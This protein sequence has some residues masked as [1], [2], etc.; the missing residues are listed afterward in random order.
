MAH[1]RRQYILRLLEQRGSIRSAALAAELGVT[2]ET[3]RTDLVALQKKGLLKRIHGGAEYSVPGVV[4]TTA[5]LAIRA[6][7]AMAKI[8][9]EHISQGSCIYADPCPFSRILAQ[10]LENKPCTFLTASPQFALHLAP[11]ALPHD[12][13]CCGGQLDKEARLFLPTNADDFFKAHRPSFAVLRPPALQNTSCAYHSESM[14][15]WAQKAVQNA[16]KCLI[17]IPASHLL[18]EAR[19]S[20]PLPDFHLITEDNIPP[21]FTP[22]TIQTI[23]YISPDIFA[24]DD[25]FVF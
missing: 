16:S 23:P 17:A 7:V 8:V 12:V 19:F 9:A 5:D 20:I 4:A 10:T 25:D 14:S 24:S 11:K 6:D 13:I 21:S 3:I 18:A 2:D 15:A 1:E 22:S